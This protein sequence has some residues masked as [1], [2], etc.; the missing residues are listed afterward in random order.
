MR[1]SIWR[2]WRFNKNGPL[3]LQAN[4]RARLMCGRSTVAMAYMGRFDKLPKADG[5]WQCCLAAA[6]KREEEK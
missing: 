4:S 3:H 1:W 2:I 5:Y 6:R